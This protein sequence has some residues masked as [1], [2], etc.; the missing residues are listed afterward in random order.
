MKLL[1]K[2]TL[3]L[4]LAAL[5]ISLGGVFLLHAVIHRYIRH[6]IDELLASELIQVKE[7]LRQHPPPAAYLPG[8]DPNVQIRLTGSPQSAP[9]VYS[10]TTILLPGEKESQPIR[11]LRATYALGNRYYGITL[12][13]SYLEFDEIA[14]ALSVGVIVCFLLVVLVL[15]GADILVTRRIWRPFYGIVDQLQ[16]YRI[17]GPDEA[18]FPVSNVA[19]FTL[20]SQSLDEMS[21]RSRQQYIQQ[22][23]FTDN[24]SH[25]M[26]TPLSVLSF[27]LDLLQQSERLDEADLDRI[28]RSQQEI[29]RLSAMNQSL[30]L[31]AKIDNHQFAQNASVNIGEL[32]TQILDNY[33][34]FAAHRCITITRL[35]DKDTHRLL[36]QQLAE[37]LFSNLIKNAFRHGAANSSVFVEVSTSRFVISNEGDP[38]P[39]PEDQLFG[40]FVRNQALSQS[41]GLG[42]SLVKEIA[43]QYDMRVRY[44]YVSGMRRHMLLVD[45]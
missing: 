45:F 8:W 23:Q 27:E 24:A 10:D 42:L 16:H 5:P 14:R 21:R 40:R 25:E 33:T 30:L 12:Q 26:Q 9:S 15:V 39:F 28:Q 37:V 38:L 32:V 2:T 17:D 29:R 18:Q 44:S 4:L 31:L 3:Y 34:D 35:I 43:E 36:N 19:E 1:H 20:L 11:M 13:Q 7:Q 6:E 41:T 22:K